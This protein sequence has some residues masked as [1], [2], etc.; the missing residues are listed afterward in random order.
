MFSLAYQTWNIPM[1]VRLHNIEMDDLVDAPFIDDFMLPENYVFLSDFKDYLNL[2][3]KVR[4][5][6]KHQDKNLHISAEMFKNISL[7]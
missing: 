6:N 1:W 2:N 7:Q 3:Q 4:K 5:I